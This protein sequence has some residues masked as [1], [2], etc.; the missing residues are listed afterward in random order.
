MLKSMLDLK[1]P[2]CATIG[3]LQRMDLSFTVD[4][5]DLMQ[6]IVEV[7]SPCE[8]VSTELSSQRYPSLSKLF[9]L[10]SLML[11]GLTNV[12]DDS[13]VR[14]EGLLIFRNRLMRNI[15][16]RFHNLEH[17]NPDFRAPK[18]PFVSLAA[19]TDPRYDTAVY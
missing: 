10:I 1:L 12:F 7:L 17:T 9:P 19:F 11:E 3:E 4:Q 18:W 14:Y 15:K 8:Q 5:W 2:I 6:G 13:P 16:H